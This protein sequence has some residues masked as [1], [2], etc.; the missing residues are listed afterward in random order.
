LTFA[1]QRQQP[2]THRPR[3]RHSQ[4]GTVLL[5]EMN[6]TQ[7]ISVDANWPAFDVLLDSR[8]EEIS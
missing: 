4:I 7:K 8:V 2:L 3:M 6:Q 1:S 5:H